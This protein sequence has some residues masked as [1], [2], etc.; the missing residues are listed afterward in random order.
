MTSTTEKVALARLLCETSTTEG[1]G[2]TTWSMADIQGVFDPQAAAAAD[3]KKAWALVK[4]G[5]T[6]YAIRRQGVVSNL[7][8]AVSA[9]QFVDVI[10]V[11]D[12]PRDPRQ[13][14]H[15]VGRHLHLPRRRWRHGHARV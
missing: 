4:D 3:G 8:A 14:R 10:P 9:D 1:I 12:R 5:Y 6:G 11:A 15:G 7:D 13:V 2:E